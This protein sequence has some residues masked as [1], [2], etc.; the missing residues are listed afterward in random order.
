[1][2]IFLC[3]GERFYA[4][5]DLSGQE[6][7]RSQRLSLARCK[8]LVARS[9]TLERRSH[10]KDHLMRFD[11]AFRLYRRIGKKKAFSSLRPS[12]LI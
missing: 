2:L 6:E 7:Q 9:I 8:R 3:T 12:I 5:Q 11:L 1:M 10:P 4:S